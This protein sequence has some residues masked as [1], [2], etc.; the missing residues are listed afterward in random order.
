MTA[1]ITVM[2]STTTTAT[3]SDVVIVL[4]ICQTVNNIWLLYKIHMRS[5]P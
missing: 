3:I 1:S 4:G 5:V 2:I